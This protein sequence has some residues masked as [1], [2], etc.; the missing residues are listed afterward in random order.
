MSYIEK[1]LMKG[2][3]GNEPFQIVESLVWCGKPKQL[4]AKISLFMCKRR[5]GYCLDVT[6][7]NC[8][9]CY[10]PYLKFCTLHSTR[11]DAISVATA[12]IVSKVQDGDLIRWARSLTE[13]K[14]LN[15]FQH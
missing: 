12:E 10:G 8:G 5:W 13:L 7:K 1:K 3:D 14:Q 9:F 11:Q 6:T 4:K 15:L 2:T